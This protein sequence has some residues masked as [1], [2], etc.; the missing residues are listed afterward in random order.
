MRSAALATADILGYDLSEAARALSQFKAPSP[1]YPWGDICGITVVDDR[2]SPNRDQSN[3]SAALPLGFK[4]YHLRVSLIAI[5]GQKILP[6]YLP[7]R[8]MG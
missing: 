3:L 7:M 1:L 5:A 8:L 6:T 4:A 2:A